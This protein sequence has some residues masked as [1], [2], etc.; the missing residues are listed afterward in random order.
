MRTGE[1]VYGIQQQLSDLRTEIEEI[2]AMVREIRRRDALDM[3]KRRLDC[4]QHRRRFSSFPSRH[5][6][7]L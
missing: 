1:V 7:L 3:G 5:A 4:R 6:G 2:T